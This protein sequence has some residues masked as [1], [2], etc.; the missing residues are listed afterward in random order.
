MYYETIIIDAIFF[1]FRFK[2]KRCVG[3]VEV[4]GPPEQSDC[5]SD[6]S[7]WRHAHNSRHL[8]DVSLRQCWSSGISFVFHHRSTEQ[9]KEKIEQPKEKLEAD[10]EC[11][12][13]IEG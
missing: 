10:S 13:N 5:N 12:E 4:K 8:P 2:C 7:D 1:F 6:L 3:G 11:V 9:V